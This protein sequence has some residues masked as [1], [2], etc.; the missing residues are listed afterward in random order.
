MQ[1][2]LDR[3]QKVFDAFQKE[4]PEEI[5]QVIAEGYRR[6]KLTFLRWCGVGDLTPEI[7]KVINILGTKYTDTRHK[8]V[9]RKPESIKLLKR[10]MPNIYV[11]FSLDGDPESRKRKAKVDRMRHP[12]VYYSYLRQTA[13]ED[14]LDAPIIFDV[15]SQ[16]GKLPWD[17]KRCCPVDSGK[18]EMENACEKCKKCFS[19]SILG[20]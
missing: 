10:D 9:T 13:D 18:M 8:V 4:D 3:Q 15:H 20:A 5:A 12:R 19:P 14:T 1:A 2:S 11:M 17:P 16:K 6:K 7:I